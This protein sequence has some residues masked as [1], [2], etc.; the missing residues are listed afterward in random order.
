MSKQRSDQTLGRPK[1]GRFGPTAVN[2]TI[3][4]SLLE[5]TPPIAC[6]LSRCS[7]GILVFSPIALTLEQATIIGQRL[8]RYQGA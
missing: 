6:S 2:L 5:G 3:P 8:P 1:L 7:E 4:L